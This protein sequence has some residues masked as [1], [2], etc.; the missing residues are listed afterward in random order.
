MRAFI[1]M[2]RADP[3]G[4]IR[5]REPVGQE[6]VERDMIPSLSLSAIIS[7]TPNNQELTMPEFLCQEEVSVRPFLLMLPSSSSSAF[8]SKV[9]IE[10]GVGTTGGSLPATISDLFCAT[11]KSKYSFHREEIC[12][13]PQPISDSN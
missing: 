3:D 10:G 9:G 2:Q 13:S 8:F 6:Q 12:I 4:F 5:S 1:K 11:H 7:I